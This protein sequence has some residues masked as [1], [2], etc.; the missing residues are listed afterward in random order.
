V[1]MK[2]MAGTFED[3]TLKVFGLNTARIV[4]V[5]ATEIPV[6]EVKDRRT[7]FIFVLEDNTLLL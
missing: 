7:D 2:A 5:Y 6:V 4:S 3:K 1:V